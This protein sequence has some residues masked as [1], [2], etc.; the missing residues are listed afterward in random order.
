[1]TSQPEPAAYRRVLGELRALVLSG[2][3]REGDRLPPVREIMARYDV[4]SGTAA[5]ALAALRSEGLVVARHGSGVFVRRFRQIWRSSP[6]R[7]SRERWQAGAAIQDADTQGR[8]RVVDVEVGEVPA[9]DWVADALGV[10]VGEP[11]V[12][13]SRSFL[14]DDRPVQLAT[15][16]FRA[17]LVRGSPVTYTDTGPGGSYAR[18]AELGHAPVTF[19]EHLR[20]RMP[21]P[22]ETAALDLPEGT[23]V[24]E[25]RRHAFTADGR[26][27]EVNRM[28]LDGS[29]YLL[30]Y[31]FPA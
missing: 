30:D 27:V 24:I 25:I 4:S 26:C 29:A 23:P 9:P 2:E 18:L 14:V 15:S 12:Y 16:Y 22:E 17:E 28:V 19:T 11:V 21:V 1:M 7:L 5:R 6:Q 20:A 10:D 3:L 8:E 13:R 31:S